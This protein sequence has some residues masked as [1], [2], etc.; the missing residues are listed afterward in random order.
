MVHGRAPRIFGAVCSVGVACVFGVLALLPRNQSAG[1]LLNGGIAFCIVIVPATWFFCETL[2]RCLL[3][4]R[5][6]ILEIGRRGRRRRFR[7]REVKA[8]THS[9]MLGCYF[10]ERDD[11][12]RLIVS[13]LLN[14]QGEF[15]R[16]ALDGVEG[17]YLMCDKLLK[18][19]SQAD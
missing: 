19:V 8:V 10:V 5:D 16:R 1:A 11:G 4:S 13:Q 2:R 7:W 9:S 12:S 15:A 6:S 17:R 3:L 14:G 18:E